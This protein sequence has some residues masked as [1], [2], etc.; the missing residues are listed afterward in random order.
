MR[1]REFVLVVA[2]PIGCFLAVERVAVEGGSPGEDLK[3]GARRSAFRLLDGG[4]I[5]GKSQEQQV[6]ARFIMRILSAA[7]PYGR[8]PRLAEEKG[9]GLPRDGV[10]NCHIFHPDYGFCQPRLSMRPQQ[11]S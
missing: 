5:K 10:W 2:F 11:A 9:L 7:A 8:L 3:H 4:Q 6:M 1:R